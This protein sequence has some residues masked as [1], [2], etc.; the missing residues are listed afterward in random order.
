[1]GRK[2]K[3]GERNALQVGL[4]EHLLALGWRPDPVTSCSEAQLRHA[5]EVMEDLYNL[6]QEFSSLRP[7]STKHLPQERDQG[8]FTGQITTLRL[9]MRIV[10]SFKGG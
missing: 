10:L 7:S 4:I 6:L 5:I 2:R 9:K 8:R 3:H 1:M